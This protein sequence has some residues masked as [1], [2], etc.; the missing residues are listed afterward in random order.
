MGALLPL[1]GDIA[2]YGK[3][4]KAGID[5]AVKQIN[6]RGGING[7]LLNVIYEDSRGIPRD[8]VTA[9]QKLVSVDKVKA[10][11]GPVASSVALAVEPIATK[12]RVILFSPAAS[13]PKLTGISEYFFR[14]WPSDVFEATV[15][16]E[17]VHSKLGLRAIAILYVNN[18]YGIGLKSEF[19]RRFQELK[20][21][22]PIVESYE[23]GASD[24]RSQLTKIKAAEP[25]AVYLAGYH[26]EMAAA[27]KQIRELGMSMQILGD[28][29]YGVQE[30]L[31][32]AGSAA[33]GA[34]FSI[35]EYDPTRG[36]ESMRLFAESFRKEYGSE[37]SIFE[38]NAY[39]AVMLLAVAIAK[40]GVSTDRIADHLASIKNYDGASGTI[41]FG[42]DREVVKPV[43][44]KVVRDGAFTYY[45]QN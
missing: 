4:C 7:A 32:I 9:F 14:D 1:T 8:G 38:A 42:P 25:N 43:S 15:L 27:T 40:V 21:T 20:G 6:E 29:D 34:I 28:G 2:E 11:I 45:G 44:I 5:L 13:S 31:K 37:P 17:F 30:L 23:Q 41:S 33:E 19:M 26:R 36:G 35:P 39:D 22:V 24:F 3:R 12:N 10:V 18:E 16:A